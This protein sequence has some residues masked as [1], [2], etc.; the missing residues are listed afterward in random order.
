MAPRLCQLVEKPIRH[1]RSFAG[2]RRRE[3]PVAG[4]AEAGDDVADLV[5][6][7]V[8]GGEVERHVRVGLLQGVAAFRRGDDA[9][10][11]HLRDADRLEDI[12]RGNRAAA[13]RQHRI[14]DEGQVDIGLRRE[15]VVVSDRLECGVVAVKPE[16]PDGGFRK[17]LEHGVGHAEPGAEDRDEADLL[18][19]L[20]ADGLVERRVHGDG[21]ELDIASRFEEEYAGD[22][23][24]QVAELGRPG[25]GRTK[26]RQLVL[27]QRMGRDLDRRGHGIPRALS[28][29]ALL[30]LLQVVQVRLAVRA[31]DQVEME[32]DVFKEVGVAGA[33]EITAELIASRA[34]DPLACAD[35]AGRMLAAILLLANLVQQLLQFRGRAQ[36]LLHRRQLGLRQRVVQVIA[37]DLPRDFRHGRARFLAKRHANYRVPGTVTISVDDG[38]GYSHSLSRLDPPDQRRRPG[39]RID[40]L[41]RFP[42]IIGQQRRHVAK[43]AEGT[44]HPLP[45]RPHFGLLESGHR[46]DD[47]SGPEI[48]VQRFL[49]ARNL[50]GDEERGE[51]QL[52]GCPGVVL[53]LGEIFEGCREFLL[54]GLV[55]K[56]LQSHGGIAIQ[57]DAVAGRHRLERDRGRHE[58]RRRRNRDRQV[59]P[60]SEEKYRGECEARSDHF[61]FSSLICATDSLADRS[62][63]IV[64]NEFTLGVGR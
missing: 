41:K 7:L 43:Y 49:E 60:E 2:S 15:L 29:S 32:L 64:A 56:L 18:G 28:H 57:Q 34:T 17:C 24:D 46:D 26:S 37:K 50:T 33:D 58:P 10:E 13:G 38:G 23:G 12:D 19:D 39:H 53:L 6:P 20:P 31:A 8:E 14:E 54:I 55:E 35:G 40:S 42:G 4:V 9:D 44:V 52:G 48:V 36:R 30:E 27:D 51:V 3:L 22:G 1:G 25:R 47:A 11:L 45:P 59:L 5:E 63:F 16:V 61:C 62:L 21:P